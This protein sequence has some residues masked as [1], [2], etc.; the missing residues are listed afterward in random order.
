MVLWAVDSSE[1]TATC[2]VYRTML[3]QFLWSFFPFSMTDIEI[4][5]GI[6]KM[7]ADVRT[8][9]L[10]SLRHQIKHEGTWV[11]LILADCFGRTEGKVG[12][13]ETELHQLEREK[14][15]E[16]RGKG[17]TTEEA[18]LPLRLAHLPSRPASKG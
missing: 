3:M 9:G 7:T 17:S 14:Q 10:H 16:E 5:S 2:N 1:E 6:G 11:L 8:D 4:A 18:G 12:A 13:R 15:L